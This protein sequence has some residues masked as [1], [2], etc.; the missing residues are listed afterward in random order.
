MTEYHNTK[1]RLTIGDYGQKNYLLSRRVYAVDGCPVMDK[2]RHSTRVARLYCVN[3]S[4]IHPHTYAMHAYCII[5]KSTARSVFI[6][7]RL[8]SPARL[9]PATSC[10]WSLHL[11]LKVASGA[12]YDAASSPEWRQAIKI[13]H[14]RWLEECHRRMRELM[15]KNK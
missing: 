5:S 15:N 8:P 10:A 6:S 14:S 2:G 4:Y 7:T 1:E 13:V 3:N 11:L 9:Y 12:K